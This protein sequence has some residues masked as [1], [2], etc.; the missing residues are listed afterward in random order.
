MVQKPLGKKKSGKSA[1][2]RVNKPKQGKA[3]SVADKIM[4]R[5]G[6]TRQRVM[7]AQLAAEATQTN[8]AQGS[9]D[10]GLG[11][12]AR[13]SVVKVDKQLLGSAKAMKRKGSSQR[14]KSG[15]GKQSKK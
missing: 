15:G 2:Q 9:T 10:L 13:P 7:E 5:I 14:K 8:A 12:G 4:H 1:T 6:G 3:R 11:G